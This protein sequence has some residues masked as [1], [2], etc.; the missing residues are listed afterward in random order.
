MCFK[1][2][3]KA[4]RLLFSNMA[5]QLND[6]FCTSLVNILKATDGT[7]KIGNMEPGEKMSIRKV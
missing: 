4:Q 1:N 7:V 6:T 3:S 5:P 2:C